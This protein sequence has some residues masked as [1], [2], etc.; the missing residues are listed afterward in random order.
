MYKTKMIPYGF[1]EC[2]FVFALIADTVNCSYWTSLMCRNA[3][4]RAL[5]VAIQKITARDSIDRSG[6]LLEH[7]CCDLAHLIW[8]YSNI[9]AN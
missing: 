7:A 1:H 2:T 8:A 3:L 6:Q 5:S 4:F 9:W